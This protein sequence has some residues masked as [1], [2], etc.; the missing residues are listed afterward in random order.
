[1]KTM[2]VKEIMRKG[3][4]S[5]APDCCI[6]EAARKM[7]QHNIGVLP[8]CDRNVLMGVVTDRDIVIR[9][10]AQG[11]DLGKTEVVK[12]MTCD[13][14]HCRQDD[15]LSTVARTMQEKKIRRILVVNREEK[16]VGM[17]SIDDLTRR[18]IGQDLVAEVLESAAA[19]RA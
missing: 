13:P 11:I 2:L 15:E 14:V 1:M 12:I 4:D 5:V 7:R 16:L 10:V 3:V 17:L 18:G 9:A 8:I 19:H 6:M